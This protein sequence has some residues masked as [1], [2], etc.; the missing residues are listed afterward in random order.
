MKLQTKILLGAVALSGFLNIAGV[1]YA[2]NLP[3]V[4][5]VEKL[6]YPIKDLGNCKNPG[7][8]RSY[9]DKGANM[10]AC[11]AYAEKNNLLSGEELRISKLIAEKMK[12]GKMPGGCKSRAECESYC[13]GNVK[14]INECIAFAEEVGV[15]GPEDLAQ[16]RMVAKALE[17]GATLPGGCKDKKS[18]ESYCADGVHID[19][20][21]TFAGKAGFM[22]P[23]ELAEAQKVAQFL[24]DGTTPGKCMSKAACKDYCDKD[25]NFSECIGF[26]EKAGFVSKEDADMARRVGGKGP[27]GCRS[28]DACEEFCGRE[29]NSDACLDFAIEKDLLTAQQEKQ[30]AGVADEIKKGLSEVPAEARPAVEACLS[31]QIGAPAYEKLMNGTG[32]PT[33]AM[34]GLIQKCFEAA[35]AD[36]VKAQMSNYKG[37]GE[38]GGPTGIPGGLSV[39]EGVERGSGV[40]SDLPKP[41][42]SEEIENLIRSRMPQGVPSGAGGMPPAGFG[43]P[44]PAR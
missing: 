21:L 30:I 23:E 6:T 11:V 5:D 14:S 1:I 16:A 28:K 3:I 36:F 44:V 33:R 8:C 22:T 4:S 43:G 15:I 41:P 29:E 17:D 24:K 9:C 20:C 13:E 25:D 12:A 38:G 32:K 31:G 42:S 35:V 19:E 7:D 40:P 27:G 34:G 39:P 18:C 26:A 37:G 10:T 2:Q